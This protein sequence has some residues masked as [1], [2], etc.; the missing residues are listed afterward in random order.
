MLVDSLQRWT[1]GVGE[2][3]MIGVRRH[4]G[5]GD[6]GLLVPPKPPTYGATV[7]VTGTLPITDGPGR[8]DKVVTFLSPSRPSMY[9][10]CVI[11][12]IV[13]LE[14]MPLELGGERLMIAVPPGGSC[15]WTRKGS[16]RG[17][18]CES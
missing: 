10:A 4:G 6:Q 8:Q 18:K 17:H 7:D 2:R 14:R 3:F 1:R 9:L 15:Q 12:Y 11:P 5:G 13:Y 16:L